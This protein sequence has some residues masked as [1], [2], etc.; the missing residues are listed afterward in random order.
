MPWRLPW[1]GQDLRLTLPLA[2]IGKAG[3][4]FE[5]RRPCFETIGAPHL[6]ANHNL[7]LGVNLYF[8]IDVSC[9]VADDDLSPFWRFKIKHKY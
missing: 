1:R 6:G 5:Y 4:P 8:W 9:R 2:G 7:Y 3:S